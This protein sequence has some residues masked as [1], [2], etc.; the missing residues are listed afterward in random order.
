MNQPEFILPNWEVP[1][2]VRATATTRTGGLSKGPYRGFNLGAHVGDEAGA[3]EG[4]RRLLRG[5]LGLPAEPAWLEQVHGNEV[6]LLED[7]PAS[8]PRADAAITRRPGV[9]LAILTADCL[10]VLFCDESGREIAAAHAGWRG[11]AAGVLQNTV[12]MFDAPADEIHAWLGPAIGPGDFE[13]GEDVLQAFAARLPGSENLFEPH[14]HDRFLADLYQLA[15]LALAG[16]GVTSVRG[17]GWSTF[18]EEERFFSHRRHC[19]RRQQGEENTGRQASL[20]WLA[21]E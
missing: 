20:I 14:G 9:P 2:N 13:V 6:V 4:N 12:A 17:G 5:R 21:S 18:T 1:A 3:V 19:Q 10:P 11:L 16:V 7:L 15:R 8:P